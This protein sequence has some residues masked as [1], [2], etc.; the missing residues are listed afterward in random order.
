MKLLKQILILF[1]LSFLG[2]SLT[3]ALS[4]PIPG[5]IIGL[6]VLFI[7]LYTK[8]LKVEDVEDVGVWLKNNMAFFFVPATV[9]IMTYL[10]IL[11]TTWVE[12]LIIVIIST[13]VTYLVTAFTALKTEGDE[14]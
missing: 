4:L 11:K 8:T 12:V 5:S 9:G 14:H 7:L 2:D 13:L 10:D 6:V 1:G 3:N